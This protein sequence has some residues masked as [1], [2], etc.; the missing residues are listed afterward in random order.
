[1]DRA[2]IDYLKEGAPDCPLIRIYGSKEPISELLGS[3]QELCERAAASVAVHDLPG[4]RAS[5]CSL[6]F[7]AGDRDEGIFQIGPEEFSWTLTPSAWCKIARV[8]E[9]FAEPLPGHSHQWLAGNEAR[10]GLGD[11]QIALLLSTDGRW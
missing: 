10:W 4:F 3:V 11:S 2:R 9:P 1:M 8:I 6:L 7:R 5:D